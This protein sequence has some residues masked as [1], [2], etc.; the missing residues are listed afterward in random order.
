MVKDKLWFEGE[1]H[2]TIIITDDDMKTLMRAIG[3]AE[4]ARR[5][6]GNDNIDDLK[7]L[8]TRIYFQMR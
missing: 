5:F 8:E 3:E 2:Y 7:R 4:Q 6:K 1:K